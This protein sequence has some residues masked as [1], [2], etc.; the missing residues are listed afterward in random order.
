MEGGGVAEDVETAPAA[1]RRLGAFGGFGVEV[2]YMIVDR[3]SLD[4]RPIAD[5]V[6]RRL[7]G[8]GGPVVAEVTRG[9]LGWSNELVLHLLELKNPRPARDLGTLAKRLQAEVRATAPLLSD[10]DARLMPGGMH[11]WM[12]PRTETELWPHEGQ[13]VYDA[14]DRIFDCRRHGWANLQA[15]HLNL[16]FCGNDEFARL[17][18]AVR[19][20]LPIIPAIAASS[21]FAEG[22]APGALDYRMEVYRTNSAKIPALAGLVVPDDCTSRAQ[23]EADVLGPM[24]SAMAEHD[25]DGL[26]RHEW[27]NSRGAI[28]R[29]DR[30][31]IEIRVADVQENPAVDV[32][33]AALLADAAR[34]LYEEEAAPL[35]AL[36]ALETA[37]LAEVLQSCT[38]AGEEAR[39]RYAPLLRVFGMAGDECSAAALWQ[40]IADALEASG[41]P[42]A[43]LWWAP[44]QRILSRGTLARRLLAAAG[45][46]PGREALGDVY[47][48]LCDCLH[49][50]R[51]F[52]A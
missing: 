24:Y 4:V 18:A 32:A 11:P 26:L 43:Q 40:R 39:V 9:D 52:E 27:L 6:L 38:R 23:Y 8:E 30:D 14:F 7:A 45:A 51:A 5:L 19:T 48:R 42:H 47:R 44:L 25:P 16:P 20:L 41:A 31:A 22:R 28:A 50:G 37:R 29:F 17:H 49:E 21:P 2:E 35:A 15:V 10:F 13:S 46:A 3:T 12:D 36:R 33:L 34:W 1:P